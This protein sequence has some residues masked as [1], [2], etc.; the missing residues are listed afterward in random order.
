MDHWVVRSI[1]AAGGDTTGDRED[2]LWERITAERERYWTATGQ[3]KSRPDGP[4][5]AGRRRERPGRRL[6]TA[7]RSLDDDAAAVDR[8]CDEAK[9]L[10]EKQNDSGGE[11]RSHWSAQF[12]AIQSRRNDVTRL[13][14]LRDTAL[15]TA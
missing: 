6:E 5:H 13:E 7:L 12:E 4:G 11:W 15:A 1:K 8:L 2:D 14:G 9:V 3:V 10:L